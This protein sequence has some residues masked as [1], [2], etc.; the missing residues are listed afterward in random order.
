MEKIKKI[1]KEI[2]EKYTE[3]IQYCEK[4]HYPTKILGENFNYEIVYL[5]SRRR[6]AWSENI[7]V[8]LN[9][10]GDPVIKEQKNGE[11]ITHSLNEWD[12]EAMIIFK[13]LGVCFN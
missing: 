3:L 10:K 12:P 8:E 4:G 9:H 11:W 1:R 13:K 2:A 7:K 6:E 5:V